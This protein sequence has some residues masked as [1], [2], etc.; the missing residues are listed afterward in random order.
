MHPKI[1]SPLGPVLVLHWDYW[2]WHGKL[3]PGQVGKI[4]S[5]DLDTLAQ[6]QAPGKRDWPGGLVEMG[7]GVNGTSQLR[8]RL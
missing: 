1:L 2:D 7:V 6:H 5:T 8:A 3:F 4:P